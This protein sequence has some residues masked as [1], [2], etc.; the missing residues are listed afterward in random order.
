MVS[1]SALSKFS[2]LDFVEYFN[3]SFESLKISFSN[4]LSSSVVN[5]LNNSTISDKF[6]SIYLK[7]SILFS[8]SDIFLNTSFAFSFFHIFGFADLFFNIKSS[9][10]RV[11]MSNSPP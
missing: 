11:G 1:A 4:S 6:F 8:I 7:S 3:N 10:L 5:K 2:Y 9:S